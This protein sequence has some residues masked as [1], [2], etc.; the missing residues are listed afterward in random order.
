MLRK[1]DLW[2]WLMNF[3]LLL[4]SFSFPPPLSHRA[5]SGLSQA[6]DTP[7]PADSEPPLPGIQAKKLAH[8]SHSSLDIALLVSP[9]Q[10]V[11]VLVL[12]LVQ[13]YCLFVHGFGPM[14]RLEFLP[15]VLTSVSCAIAVLLSWGKFMHLSFAT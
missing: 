2:L 1:I 10:T 8:L 4:F 3:N 15:L 6:A 12:L 9:A 13:V 7:A 11:Y 14:K 5:S